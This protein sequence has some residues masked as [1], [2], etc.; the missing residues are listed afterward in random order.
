MAELL[1]S[2]TILSIVLFVVGVG[3]M[4]AEFFIP[5]FGVCGILGIIL[6]AADIFVTAK[7][8]EQGLILAAFIFIILIILFL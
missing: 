7:S 4:V 3:L 1:S 6:L 5:G 2:I 8:V